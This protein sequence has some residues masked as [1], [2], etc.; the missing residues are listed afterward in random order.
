M[1]ASCTPGNKLRIEVCFPM[2]CYGYL[3]KG[4][5]WDDNT[6]QGQNCLLVQTMKV[7]QQY[8]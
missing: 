8:K 7:Q 6:D 1:G 4:T 5:M 3:T 2:L